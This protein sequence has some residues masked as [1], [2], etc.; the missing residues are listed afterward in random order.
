MLTLVTKEPYF[1]FDGELYQQVD[2]VAMG[3]PLGLTIANI[4]LCHYVDIWLRTCSFEFKASYYKCYVNDIFVLFE[5]ETQVESFKNFINICHPK[6]K[7]TF[8]KEQ[9]N[10]FN[11]LDVTFIRED[12]FYHLGLL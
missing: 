6:I 4:F 12:S 2:S 5:S 7:F 1:L 3:S 11:F 10:C 9:N 8:E